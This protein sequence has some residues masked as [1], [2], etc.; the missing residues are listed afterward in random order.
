MYSYKEISISKIFEKI[1]FLRQYLIN[2]NIIFDYFTSYYL[3]KRCT[4]LMYKILITQKR[5]KYK[6]PCNTTD[7]LLLS[8]LAV[9]KAELRQLETYCKNLLVS[10]SE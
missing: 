3:V 6:I 9:S 4:F 2:I 7:I 1:I 8:L 10:K 5:L